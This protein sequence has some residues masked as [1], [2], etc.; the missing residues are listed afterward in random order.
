LGNDLTAYHFPMPIPTP[1]ALAHWRFR[2]SRLRLWWW[3]YLLISVA[4]AILFIRN[5]QARDPYTFAILLLIPLL[6]LRQAWK[7]D[8]QITL[9]DQHL[10]APMIESKEIT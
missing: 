1:Q 8:R 5:F 6:A 9:C 10:K 4:G 2:R 7:T 3:I